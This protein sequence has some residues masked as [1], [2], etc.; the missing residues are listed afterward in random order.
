MLIE[1]STPASLGVS[2]YI[3]AC[4]LEFNNKLT[5]PVV[6]NYFNYKIGNTI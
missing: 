6:D 5:I 4:D 2:T 1:T 3:V